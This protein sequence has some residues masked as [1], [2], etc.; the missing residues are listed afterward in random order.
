MYLPTVKSG[1]LVE[2]YLMGE[3]IGLL[4]TDCESD[5]LIH[6]DHVLFVYRE[7]DQSPCYAV[8]AE[9]NKLMIQHEEGRFL[10]VF[11]GNGHMNMGMSPHWRD[12]D[13]FV[14]RALEVVMEHFKIEVIPEVLPIPPAQRLD[15]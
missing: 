5:G 2:R 10:G 11:P 4:V 6:Y 1:R 15:D 7:G 8:A 3:Y 13:K 9:M 14:Q 12:L